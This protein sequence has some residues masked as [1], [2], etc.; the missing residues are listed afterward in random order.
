MV[1]SRFLRLISFF[2]AIFFSVQTIFAD[3]IAYASSCNLLV[4]V[5]ESKI[6]YLL[7]QQ[8][9][10]QSKIESE[11]L[12]EMLYF[13][14]SRSGGFQELLDSD[15]FTERKR[16]VW[17]EKVNDLL[18]RRDLVTTRSGVGADFVSE[19]FSES[20]LFADSLSE[21]NTLF[22]S[23]SDFLVEKED[24]FSINAESLELFKALLISKRITSEFK[25]A[26]LSRLTQYEDE[27]LALLVDVYP[28]MAADKELNAFIKAYLR[29]R[30]SEALAYLEEL[31]VDDMPNEIA[32]LRD[33]FIEEVQTEEKGSLSFVRKTLK[34]VKLFSCL[35]VF[36]FLIGC[37][38]KMY[39][40]NINAATSV[41]VSPVSD[42]YRIFDADS[43][44]RQGM[45]DQFEK[46][47][48]QYS[49]M[50]IKPAEDKGLNVIQ[51]A[52]AG[53]LSFFS[54]VIVHE[55]GHGEVA[56]EEGAY[57]IRYR[58]KYSKLDGAAFYDYDV[59]ELPS[60]SLRKISMA[61]IS[62]TRDHYNAYIKPLFRSDMTVSQ[63]Q[64]A[65]MLGFALRSDLQRYT[66]RTILGIAGP[67]QLNDL[68][69]FGN[70]GGFSLKEVY[71]LS[72]ADFIFNYDE[73]EFLW[74]ASLGRDVKM[75]DE[76]RI[77]PYFESNGERFVVGIRGGW[78]GTMDVFDNLIDGSKDFFGNFFNKDKNRTES[79]V[80]GTSMNIIALPVLLA[81]FR[82]RLF[83][84]FRD[85]SGIASDYADVLNRKILAAI[86][87]SRNSLISETHLWHNT[88]A[89][90]GEFEVL[91]DLRGNVFDSERTFELLLPE[92]VYL[93]ECNEKIR[94]T[95][96]S[97]SKTIRDK[98]EDVDCVRCVGKDESAGVRAESV[99]WLSKETIVPQ[100]IE[101]ESS[102]D[103]ISRGI[104]LISFQA[105][106]GLLSAILLEES[107]ID[108]SSY[109]DLM[110]H[111]AVDIGSEL[112]G[113][114]IRALEQVS[115]VSVIRTSA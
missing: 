55:H 99:L 40:P 22:S 7:A 82:K 71:A 95:V 43:D 89:E 88:L 24:V 75:P 103:V 48:F 42:E 54:R 68:K 93:N 3:H 11:A 16:R 70:D 79:D 20:D 19:V 56:K 51:S 50:N 61:G 73:F 107:G 58:Y 114:L 49:Q 23:F 41:N 45:S 104:D 109:T 26:L 59:G 30:K 31:S 74:N 62:A 8:T 60:E 72:A 14:A 28:F 77:R 64:Y 91:V 76:N 17:A 39:A 15:Y 6:N 94:F 63:Q 66:A 106:I 92:M 33:Q 57:N 65:A 97:D 111:I 69:S 102:E 13:A 67:D 46:P 100:F 86:T 32:V 44:F 81:G 115:L 35:L 80:T 47:G 84:L 5:K 36:T 53:Y 34:A 52:A 1:V 9:D 18:K 110:Q 96:I 37:S 2:V 25:L 87:E 85:D 90:S 112:E 29:E 83:A 4:H 10:T 113:E 21:V 105:P 101:I 78:D 12:N 98:V 38:T 108:A 27:I